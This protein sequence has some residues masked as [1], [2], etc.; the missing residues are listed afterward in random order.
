VIDATPLVG[1]RI[2]LR[3]TFDVPC[4]ACGETVVAI[5]QGAGPHA[6]SLR[7]AACERQRGWLPRALTEFLLEMIRLFGPLPDGMTIRNTQFAQANAAAPVLGAIA[8]PQHPHPETET[9][10]DCD[11]IRN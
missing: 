7:C 2:R 3:R 8:A 5:A 4:C 1:M 10:S 6:A 9:E 11:D